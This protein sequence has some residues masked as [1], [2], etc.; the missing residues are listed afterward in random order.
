MNEKLQAMLAGLTAEELAELASCLTSEKKMLDPYAGHLYAK[1]QKLSDFVSEPTQLDRIESKL[2]ILMDLI[3]DEP[4]QIIGVDG[5]VMGSHWCDVC[6]KMVFVEIIPD[7]GDFRLHCRTCGNYI[8][9]DEDE[10][11]YDPSQ[12]IGSLDDE[13]EEEDTDGPFPYPT[14]TTERK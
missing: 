14:F 8:N 5:E 3:I 1:I 11:P 6:N 12:F 13:D 2:D 7:V 10:E 4:I 9:E